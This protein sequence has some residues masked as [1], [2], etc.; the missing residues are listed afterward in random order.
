MRFGELP[1]LTKPACN[2]GIGLNSVYVPRMAHRR[3]SVPGLPKRSRGLSIRL[4][5]AAIEGGYGSEAGAKGDLADA[6]R[7]R[8]KQQARG[9]GELLF[10]QEVPQR[11][12]RNFRSDAA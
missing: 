10:A 3:L 11:L 6:Q 8:P 2:I 12:P 7:R 4:P 5:E 9:I 1:T